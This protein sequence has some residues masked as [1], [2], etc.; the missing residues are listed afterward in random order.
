MLRPVTREYTAGDLRARMPADCRERST[1]TA[2]VLFVVPTLLYLA[3]LVAIVA[4][5]YWPLRL[6]F[7]LGAGFF[8]AILFVIGHD[9]CH[10]A[11]TNH[12]WLNNVIGRLALF[13]SWHPYTGWE[14]AHNHIHHGWTNLRGRDYAWAPLTKEDYDRLSA[15]GR[16]RERFYRSPFGFGAYY[17]LS[18]YLRRT[19]WPNAKFRGKTNMLRLAIDNLLCI[20]FI[21]AQAAAMLAAARWLRAEDSPWQLIL[22]GQVLPFLI[23]N[24]LIG[25]LIFLHHTHPGIPWFDNQE[26]WSF[27]QGQVRG[28][29]HVMFPGPINWLIQ[30]IMEHTAHHADPRVPLY[31]LAEAQRSLEDAMPDDVLIHNFSFR[32]FFYTLRVCQLYDYREHCWVSYEGRTTSSCTMLR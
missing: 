3:T 7:S 29:A 14:H 15:F 6:L 22:F 16:F 9:A 20:G 5:P 25:F 30:N 28:T 2:L 27:Y 24:W 18:V 23:F 26:E 8:T 19:L 4:V 21:V 32:S 12:R 13:P 31:K 11:F 1:T 17:M 10:G